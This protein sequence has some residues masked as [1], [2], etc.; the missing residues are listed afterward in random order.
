MREF[1]PLP[2]T[3]PY[4]PLIITEYRRL[5]T[6]LKLR[7]NRPARPA[8]VQPAQPQPSILPTL[9]AIAAGLGLLIWL[10]RD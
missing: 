9:L 3:R 8:S 2:G 5:H 1:M 6:P 4:H 7:L 10:L